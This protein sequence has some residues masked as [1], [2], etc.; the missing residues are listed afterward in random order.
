M[1]SWMKFGL[2]WGVFMFVVLN[3][4]FPLIDGKPLELNR[5]LIALPVWLVFGLAF[6]YISRKK[7]KSD[8]K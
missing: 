4:V 6:G 1:K 5:L 3:I 2:G 7:Q 8:N